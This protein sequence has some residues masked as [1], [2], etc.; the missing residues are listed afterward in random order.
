MGGRSPLAAAGPRGAAVL[1]LLLLGRLALCLAVEGKKGRGPG[2]EG[3]GVPPPFAGCAPGDQGAGAA[4]G[5]VP[6]PPV[7]RGGGKV[8]TTHFPKKKNQIKTKN[9]P[10]KQREGRNGEKTKPI[11]AI[12]QP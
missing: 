4:G 11:A 7:G 9:L 8:P 10:Q 1:V 6:R 12:T 5:C 2:V 3:A